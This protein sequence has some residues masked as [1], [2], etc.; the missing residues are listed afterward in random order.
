MFF[1]FLKIGLKLSCLKHPWALILQLSFGIML[2]YE[3]WSVFQEIG[4]KESN[5]IHLKLNLSLRFKSGNSRFWTHARAGWLALE[6]EIRAPSILHYFEVRSSGRINA[7]VG[8]CVTRSSGCRAPN[9]AWFLHIQHFW[10]FCSTLE[11]VSLSSS[12]NLCLHVCSSGVT[13]ARVG[14]LFSKNFENIFKVH[15][16]ILISS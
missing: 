13:Y 12:R 3:F 7:R 9:R 1:I 15:I 14:P 8:P 2:N 10:L 11:R 5:L 16:F 6:R 4:P